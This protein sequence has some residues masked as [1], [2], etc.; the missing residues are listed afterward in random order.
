MSRKTNQISVEKK[1]EKKRVGFN[2]ID[3]IL[4]LITLAVIIAAVNIISPMSLIK[5]LTADDSHK[6]EYTV[7]IQN[8]DGE[9]IEKIKVNDQ[10]VD[11]VSKQDLGIVVSVYNPEPYSELGYNEE[12]GEGVLMSYPDKYNI[13]VIITADADYIRGEGYS[14]NGNRIAVGEK[15]SLRFPDFVC[16]GYC[17]GFSEVN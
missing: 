8:V 7:E 11:S 17:I 10:A 12:K 6:I 13:T 1:K 16:E 5:K 2:F 9:Y 14:V 15:M 3:V 4:I